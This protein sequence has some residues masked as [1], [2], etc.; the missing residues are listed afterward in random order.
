MKLYSTL[1]SSLLSL[2]ELNAV[3]LFSPLDAKKFEQDNTSTT[4]EKQLGKDLM[5]T[6]LFG[7]K[8]SFVLLSEIVT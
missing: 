5:P 1:I 7:A 8:S 3:W 4:T 2:E 6:L